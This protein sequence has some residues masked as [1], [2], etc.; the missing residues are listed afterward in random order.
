MSERRYTEEEVAEIFRRATETLTRDGTSV[1]NS[2][3]PASGALGAGVNTG[4]ET[5]VNPW[6]RNPHTT[7]ASN[8]HDVL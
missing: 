3:V 4:P 8:T 1:A 5:N 2:K 6:A 7:S